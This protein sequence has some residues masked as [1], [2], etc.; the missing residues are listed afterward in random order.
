MA[1][2]ALLPLTLLLAFKA[3]PP[4]SEFD[5]LVEQLKAEETRQAASDR[6]AE[7]A[8]ERDL[9]KELQARAEGAPA[10][11]AAALQRAAAVARYRWALDDETARLLHDA[12]GFVE[13][14]DTFAQGPPERRRV[15]LVYLSHFAEP[16]LVPLLKVWAGEIDDRNRPMLTLLR[17]VSGDASCVPELTQLL[18][19]D[20]IY[21]R[22]AAVALA[23]LLAPDHLP[24]LRPLLD[25]PRAAPQAWGLIDRVDA[26]SLRPDAQRLL[27]EGPPELRF[28][29][30]LTLAKLGD[31]AGVDLLADALQRERDPRGQVYLVELLSKFRPIEALP[32]FQSLIRH[33]DGAGVRLGLEGLLS[34]D[35]ETAIQPLLDA[36]GHAD[37]RRVA[38]FAMSKLEKIDEGWWIGPARAMIKDR[39][40]EKRANGAHLLGLTRKERHLD[41]LAALLADPEGYV[42]YRALEAIHRISPERAATEAAK[43]LE[44]KD[45]FVRTLAA[46]IVVAAAPVRAESVYRTLLASPAAYPRVAALQKLAAMNVADIDDLARGFLKDATPAVRLHG[47]SALLQRNAG[48][49]LD[50][51]FEIFPDLGE[52]SSYAW[53]LLERHASDPALAPRFAREFL[54]AESAPNNRILAAGWL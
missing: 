5:R 24:L 17:G 16:C 40:R 8:F 9:R 41:A 2:F 12:F 42:Q 11:A 6:L 47:L 33:P 51:F 1:A 22:P 14:S 23:R 25:D 31:R 46:E 28:L 32:A 50:R 4:Q 15:L 43:L 37:Q 13:L 27:K 44:A 36:L 26:A 48:E 52:Q 49:A 34:I 29:A 54:N 38:A 35:V 18:K 7:L 45:G 3:A 19:L 10:E 21:A 20:P 39:S 30:A 53:L